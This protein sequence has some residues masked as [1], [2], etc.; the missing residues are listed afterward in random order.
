MY[1]I[2]EHLAPYV[3]KF[4]PILGQVNQ[5]EDILH[6]TFDFFSQK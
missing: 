4:Y 3:Y 6:F 2:Y 1:A 5:Y